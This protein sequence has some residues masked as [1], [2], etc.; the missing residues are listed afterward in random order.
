MASKQPVYMLNALWFRPEGG[1][2]LYQTYLA[3][4]Q[5]VIRELGIGARMLEAYVPEEMLIGD[6][7][8][9][10]LFVVEYPDRD[11]FE[12]L[13]TSEQY[14]PVRALRER[15]IEKSLLIRCRRP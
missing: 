10:L 8:P 12:R 11:A 13:V 1:A 7:D 14:Q 2:E 5:R 15:A 3:E 6:W 9:D 4:A